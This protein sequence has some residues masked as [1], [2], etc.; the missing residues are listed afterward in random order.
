MALDLFLCDIREGSSSQ[1]Q[2]LLSL[3]L[4]QVERGSSGGC[5]AP[6]APSSTDQAGN[7]LENKGKELRIRQ[8]A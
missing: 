8:T 1:T 4:A 2:G 5:R 6:G 3:E 7:P